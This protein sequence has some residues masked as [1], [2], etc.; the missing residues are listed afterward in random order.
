MIIDT[1]I[2][3]VIIL[4]DRNY[5]LY[6]G[7]AHGILGLKVLILEYFFITKKK[8]HINEKKIWKEETSEDYLIAPKKL[9]I[10]IIKI[11]DIF[12][13][14]NNI[15]NNFNITY[16]KNNQ[17]YKITSKNILYALSEN[18]PILPKIELKIINEDIIFEFQK[19]SYIIGEKALYFNKI[20]Q[21]DIF[22]GEGNL[23]AQ[24]IYQKI[25]N[26]SEN[27][28]IHSTEVI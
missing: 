25:N 9:N 14:F 11:N 7:F 19:N 22:T 16:T 15:S 17:Y 13:N 4:T 5:G 8:P 10:P 18:H 12:N 28:S 26:S 20:F 6:A 24:I 2:Y 23:V 21:Q 1:N 3:D 27:I